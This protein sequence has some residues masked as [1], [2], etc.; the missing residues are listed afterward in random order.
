MLA[1]VLDRS[2]RLAH[3]VCCAIRGRVARWLRPA[4]NSVVLGAAADLVRSRRALVAENARLRRQLIVLAR[5]TKRPRLT[6]RDRA[7][8]VLLAS[9]AR[10][11][12]QALVIVQPATPLRWH[13]A[14]FRLL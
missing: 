5:S 12:R 1:R 3:T 10:A 2:C 7:L 8:L 14:G 9:R 6:R 4:G 13:R 11:W